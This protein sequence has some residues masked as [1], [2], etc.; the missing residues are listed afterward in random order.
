RLRALHHPLQHACGAACRSPG[1]PPVPGGAYHVLR[2]RAPAAVEL[3]HRRAFGAAGEGD[4][5][6]DEYTVGLVARILSRALRQLHIAHRAA[7]A[8]AFHQLARRAVAHAAVGRLWGGVRVA[9]YEGQNAL[10]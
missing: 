9:L 4:D 2:T 6:R 1:T 7:A 3:P 10:T 8:H 5:D